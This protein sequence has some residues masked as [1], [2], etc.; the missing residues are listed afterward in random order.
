MGVS[1]NSGGVVVA[2]VEPG[3]FA[4]DIG[5]QAGDVIVSIN[6]QSINSASTVKSVMDSAKPG[7]AMAFQLLRNAN[8]KW[9]PLYTA[10]TLR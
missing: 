3:S 1:G 5:I 10:G 4:E 6:R 8:G 2:A 7:Q 9:T